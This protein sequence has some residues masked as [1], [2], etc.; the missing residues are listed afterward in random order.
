MLAEVN[1]IVLIAGS[2]VALAVVTGAVALRA[3]VPLLL[4]FLGIGVFAGPD[5]VAVLSLP[6]PKDAFLLGSIALAVILWDAG[7]DT[8]LR[9]FRIAAGPGLVVATMGTLGTVLLIG[10]LAALLLGISWGQGFLVAATLSSTDAAAVFLLVRQGGIKLKE[11]VQSV[12]EIE[13]GTNDPIAIILVLAL[14][15]WLANPGGQSMGAVAFTVATQLGVG[16]IAGFAGGKLIG[17]AVNRLHLDEGLYPLLVLSLVLALFGITHLLQGSGFLAVYVAGLVA[18]NSGLR[19][20]AAINRFQSGLTWLAQIGMFLVLGVL[21]EPK[22]LGQVLVPALILALVLMF[23]ARPAVIALC[24]RPFGFS[25]RDTAFVGWVGLRGAVSVLLALVPT[26]EGLPAGND[27]LAVVFVVVIA[28]LLIQGRTL[29]PLGRRLGVLVPTAEGPVDR[30]ELDLPGEER[31]ELVAYTI[32]AD[33]A[34]LRGKRVPRWARPALLMRGGKEVD[35]H[36]AHGLETGDHVYLFANP[37]RVPE[38]DRLFQGLAPIDAEA[39][40]SLG[41]FSV[42]G[43]TLLNA[44]ASAYGFDL[45]GS[46]LDPSKSVAQAFAHV[47]GTGVAVGDRLHLGIVELVARRIEGDRVVE[48]GL[49]V[50]PEPETAE[51]VVA[52]VPFLRITAGILARLRGKG[53]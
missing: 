23:V 41:E 50:E 33:S 31:M 47:F 12:L 42:D 22:L 18:G 21:A 45:K 26:L 10:P 39:E 36:A 4:V 28:S 3:G 2:L 9:A 13:S 7:F 24:L 51:A 52:A 6:D 20:A 38:L 48:A 43:A 16:A 40:A 32:R 53:R 17:L 8:P 44:L 35:Y 19:R 49:E 14:A 1:A 15:G 34:V 11:R 27:L 46:R 37:A 29:A 25:W 30:V 5:G